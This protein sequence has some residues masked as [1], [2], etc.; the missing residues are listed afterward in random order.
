MQQMAPRSDDRRRLIL[1]LFLFLP[2]SIDCLLIRLFSFTRRKEEEGEREGR[3]SR[4]NLG[5]VRSRARRNGR[6]VMDEDEEHSS[7]AVRLILPQLEREKKHTRK[8]TA[9]L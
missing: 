6:G 3:Q 1:I 8:S 4:T 2:N 5:Q 7:K 9:K